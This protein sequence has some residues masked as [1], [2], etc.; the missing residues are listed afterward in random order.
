[1]A[2]VGR[3]TLT[4]IA[5]EVAGQRVSDLIFHDLAGWLMMPMALGI[6]LVELGILRRLFMQVKVD[7][8]VHVSPSMQ[9]AR[10]TEKPPTRRKRKPR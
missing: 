5:Y 8:R 1:V 6:L 4:T 9:L 7:E 3:I 2:N 10:V